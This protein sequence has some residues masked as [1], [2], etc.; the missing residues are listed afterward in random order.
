MHQWA[1][2]VLHP[3][4]ES[5]SSAALESSLR[6][7]LD[8]NARL[9]TTAVALGL[10]VPGAR[11]RIQRIEQLLERPLL[12]APEARHELYMAIR[13]IDASAA[14]DPAV[15]RHVLPPPEHDQDGR[16][17]LTAAGR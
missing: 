6:T 2:I 11:K 8:N 5:T 17:H 10:S 13:A 15:R 9:S 3:I 14:P 7:W 16:P 12:H 4:R 1:R